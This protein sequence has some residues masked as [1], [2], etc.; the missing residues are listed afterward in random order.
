MADRPA[1]SRGL[2]AALC[3]AAIAAGAAL[4]ADSPA[5]APSAALASD[6]LIGFIQYIR[7]PG[8][9][10]LRRW[11]VC[12]APGQ[13][14]PDGEW[15]TA[16]GRPIVVRALAAN[17]APDRCQ[18]LDLTGLTAAQTRAMLDRTRRTPV[19]TIGDGEA[20]CTAGGVIC[21]R[22]AAAGGGFEVNLSA[23]Q[24]AG[25]AASAQLLMLGRRRQT[26][27]AAP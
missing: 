16:R 24:D 17:E 21:T 23:L 14:I 4:A 18:I 12:V 10:E 7:W 8:E 20:F 19:V 22:T 11:D 2:L 26:A 15:P 9:G 13:T 3:F 27:G 1:A 5:R 6:R 25:L